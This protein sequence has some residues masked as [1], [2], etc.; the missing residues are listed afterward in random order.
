MG[1]LMK[2]WI[3]GIK[4]RRRRISRVDV[5]PLDTLIEKAWRAASLPQANYFLSQIAAPARVHLLALQLVLNPLNP[6]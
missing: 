3:R 1:S 5:I 6:P 4:M 2:Y